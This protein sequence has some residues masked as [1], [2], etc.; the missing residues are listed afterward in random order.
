MSVFKMCYSAVMA[1]WGRGIPVFVVV[2]ILANAL[3][4]CGSFQRLLCSHE[5]VGCLE[6]SL[7]CS[8]ETEEPETA[9]E[10][11]EKT[12]EGEVGEQG[13]AKEEEKEVCFLDNNL[14]LNSGSAATAFLKA[15]SLSVDK[16]V[17]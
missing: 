8:G 1:M 17:I 14:F 15:A 11:A 12:P 16:N 5:S 10:G 13:A 4:H 7:L 9:A 3:V 2:A 6:L